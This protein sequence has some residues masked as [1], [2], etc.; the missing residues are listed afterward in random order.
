MDFVLWANQDIKTYSIQ[1]NFIENCDTSTSSFALLNYTNDKIER[2]Q[3]IEDENKF[4]YKPVST[5]EMYY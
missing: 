5:E 1:F 3:K 4:P 2:T